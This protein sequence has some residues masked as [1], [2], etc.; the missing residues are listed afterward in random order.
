MFSVRNYLKN[1]L[2][3]VRDFARFLIM[4]NQYLDAK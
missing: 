3:C 4:F 2:S 1:T